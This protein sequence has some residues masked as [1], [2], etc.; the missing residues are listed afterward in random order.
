MLIY[1]RRSL[2]EFFY[3]GRNIIFEVYILVSFPIHKLQIEASWTHGLNYRFPF[4]NQGFLE[5]LTKKPEQSES[6][7]E[8]S[9][10]Q[11]RQCGA[12]IYVTNKTNV[13]TASQDLRV[14][15]ASNTQED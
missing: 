15:Q 14:E 12:K 7:S 4:P 9:P 8:A 1:F 11:S 13:H 2:K 10:E 5:Y 3:A 6:L